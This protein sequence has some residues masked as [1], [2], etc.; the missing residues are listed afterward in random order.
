MERWKDG[1]GELEPSR[2]GYFCGGCSFSPTGS[3][4]SGGDALALTVESESITTESL[5][6][7]TSMTLPKFKL[8]EGRQS[9]CPHYYHSNNDRSDPSALLLPWLNRHAGR[10]F[11]LGRL[12]EAMRG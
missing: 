11:G 3:R 10:G 9:R 2:P 8:L 4:K 1:G 5:S 6:V 7:V 12:L